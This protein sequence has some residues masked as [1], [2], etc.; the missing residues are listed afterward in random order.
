MNI[1]HTTINMS[2]FSYNVLPTAVTGCYVTLYCGM[3]AALIQDEL[4]C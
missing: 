2:P 1:S 3:Q 4:K